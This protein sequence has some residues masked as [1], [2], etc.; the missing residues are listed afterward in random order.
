MTSTAATARFY[1]SGGTLS[2]D[3]PSYVEREADRDL[4]EGLTRGEFCYVLTSRQM[5]KSSLMVHT[6][7]RLRR[8]GVTVVVLDF[9]AIGHNLTAEQWY[10]GLLDRVGQQLDLEDELEEYW[11]DHAR[12][13]P[14]Q[15]WMA[16]LHEVVLARRSGKLVIFVDEI[17]T[18]RSLP[19]STDEFFA[20]V[21]ECYNRRTEDPEFNR[22]TFCLLGVATPSD[23]IRDTRTTPFNIGR[24]IELTDFTEAEA[25]PLAEGLD[26]VVTRRREGDAGQRAG[27]G[28]R[29]SQ[30]LL[31]RVLYW[32][33][34]H[35][36]LTQ[37]LCQA[38][39]DRSAASSPQPPVAPFRQVD[40]LCEGLF[41][42]HGAREQDDNLIF[43]RE[44]L[45]RSEVDRASLL[46]L[47]ARVC[48]RQPVWDDNTNELVS[49]LRLSGISRVVNG[50]LFMRNR[51]YQRVF[52]AEW[53]R[54]HMPDAELRRQRLAY[55]RGLARAG[56]AAG[57][58]IAAMA[59]LAGTAV[60]QARQAERSRQAADYQRDRARQLASSLQAA[61]Q[62][63]QQQWNRANL[64][65]DRARGAALREENQRVRA[66]R[67][68]QQ[69]EQEGHRAEEQR[70]IAVAQ[71]A[72]AERQRQV[73]VAQ[74]VEAERE[75]RRAVQEKRVAEEQR[76]LSRQRLVRLNIDTG[77]RLVDEGDAL[78]SLPWF[79]QALALDQGQPSRAAMD[80]M[81]LA[82]VLQQSPRVV[83]L[84]F[85][86]RT[87]THAVFSPDGSQVLTTSEDHTARLW[88]TVTGRPVIPPIRHAGHVWYAAF[89]P[90]GHRVVTASRDSTASVWDARTGQPLTP[91]LK[92]DGLVACAVFSPDGR[93]VATGSWD[94]TAR[95]WDAVTGQPLTPALRHGLYVHHVAFSPDGQR[96]VTASFDHTARVWD[97]ATGR[98]LTSPLKHGDFVTHAAFSPDGRRIVTVSNDNTA[99]IWDATTGRAV[100]PPLQHD[101]IVHYA[102]FSP[103][104]RHVVTASE[105]RTARVWDSATGHEFAP[106]L[107]HRGGVGYALFSPDGRRIVT[108]SA[109]RTA[110]VWDATSGQPLTPPLKHSSGVVLAAFDPDGHIL[111]ATA[112]GTVRLWDVTPAEPTVPPLPHASI[113]FQASFSRDGKRIVTASWDQ[114][115]RVWDAAT[116][117]PLTPPLRHGRGVRCA[118]FS[119]D[120]R[121]V[122]TA[123]DDGTARVW[124]AVTGRP[125]TPPLRHREAVMTVAFSPDGRRVA[126][127]SND[128]TARVWDAASGK[129]ITPPLKHGSYAWDAAFSPDGRR[130]VTA[131]VEGDN[132][133]RV[134]D[135]VTGR[136]LTPPLKHGHAV[137]HAAF[138]PDGRR[139]LSASNDNTAQVWDAAT[140]RPL[141]PP[142]K[143]RGEVYS[144]SFSADGRRV[145]TASWDQ[146]ARVWDATTGWP[147][148]APLLHSA[149]VWHAAFSPDG[150]RVATACDDGTA[151]VWDAETGQPLTAPLPHRGAVE[152]VAFSPDGRFLL[153]ATAGEARLWDLPHEQRPTA[154]VR[155]LAQL[156]SGEQIEASTTS[157]VPA[158]PGMLRSAWQAM[159]TK[160]PAEFALSP[161]RVLRWHEQEAAEARQAGDRF[162]ALQHLDRLIEARPADGALRVLRAELHAESGEWG[163]AAA[164]YARAIDLGAWSPNVGYRLAL[165]RLALSD[166]EG[167]RRSCA[168]LLDRS[169]Q[170]DDP[171]VANT[172]AWTCALAPG[173]VEDLSRPLQRA[174]TA[175]ANRPGDAAVR[176]TLGDLLYRAG[177]HE[178]AIRRLNE[179]I[180]LEGHGGTAC[181]WLFLAMAHHR[182]ENAGEARSWLSKA[183]G[184]LERAASDEPGDHGTRLSWEERLELQLL[185]R[186]AEALIA[187]VSR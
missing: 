161:A 181:D 46:D 22:L 104:G 10:D 1:V 12:L 95:V 178:E 36:Y 129:P 176:N 27:R 99:R 87:V 106:R 183:V 26:G 123:S 58:I 33:G 69:A 73:A 113:V 79:A 143:H 38:A 92:H 72:E 41:L 60:S 146:T 122:A 175:V 4:Y 30:A 98:P 88:D 62:K 160:Y 127:A 9:T 49:L 66:E 168:D 121:Q 91:P 82:S 55:R 132:S 186:E 59:G 23:L 159:R 81:R 19:F 135:A 90:D 34:G 102:A 167:Y 44:R 101:G 147:L 93:R 187:P 100:T 70:G 68:R 174:E 11:L 128:Y 139:V 153:T 140:G 8:E 71:R 63:A 155:M 105:D 103:D 108:A 150:R 83:R 145:V 157:A 158:E 130:V 164:E 80:R 124:D 17:D 96:I 65:A 116:G 51:I 133:A 163:V 47:Y 37:R 118:A 6:A 94:R 179:G 48:R 5:G 50:R 15:R 84:W 86:D 85:H 148:T 74:R 131:G 64:E 172:V 67:A 14:L 40:R 57:V 52:D 54:T 117:R 142:L 144:A 115:A 120:G 45:L 78:S 169:G 32:T 151:R 112:D 2:H 125:L 39:A 56:A 31:R 18:I 28:S 29:E 16:A 89:S 76:E 77:W 35:P 141:I 110:R 152:H 137:R 24:R 119:P 61:L 182:L 136:P 21:R 170:S 42:S 43:V 107:K 177:R 13:G 134:W 138:S 3:A 171:E 114:S 20:G 109:D 97:A 126:T 111:T 173:S 7:Q 25:A 75:R 165:T 166:R 180:A 162:A 149:G 154:D 53:V 156:R 185:R 184:W